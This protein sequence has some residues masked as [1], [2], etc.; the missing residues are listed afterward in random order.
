VALAAVYLG[1]FVWLV[2]PLWRPAEAITSRPT[3]ALPVKAEGVVGIAGLDASEALPE[4]LPGSSTGPVVTAE[5]GGEEAVSETVTES[6]ESATESSEASTSSPP[7]S[8]ESS[9]P[10]ETI[11]SSEG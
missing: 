2:S 11:I 5:T 9:Q 4:S 1:A 7:P 6:S 10:Q 8:S 3:P